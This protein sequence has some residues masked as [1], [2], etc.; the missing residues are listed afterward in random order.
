MYTLGLCGALATGQIDAML[1][2]RDRAIDGPPDPEEAKRYRI[3]QGERICG[4]SCDPSG[5]Y[6]EQDKHLCPPEC[7]TGERIGKLRG[8]R[9]DDVCRTPAPPLPTVEHTATC[10]DNSVAITASGTWML[11]GVQTAPFNRARR[12][13]V[14]ASW[15]RWEHDTP[16]VLVCFLIGRLGLSAENLASLDSEERQ[17]HDILW[18]PNATDAG[19]PTIK[20]YHWWRAAASLLPP[21]GSTRG[22]RIAA[23]VDDDSFLHLGNLVTD[24]QKLHCAKHLHYGSLAF[25]GYDP[26]I[27]KMC[28]WSWQARGGNYRKERCANRGAYEPFPFMN[29]VLELLSAPLVRHVARSREIFDFVMRA[30]RAVE[31]RKAGGWGMSLKHGQRGPR[32]WRQNEDVALGFW[33][34]RAER[35]GAFNVTWV[36]INDRAMNMGC[37]STK[38]MYQRPRNDTISVHFLKRPGGLECA[39]MQLPRACPRPAL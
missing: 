27:W 13:G 16:G 31:A 22:L 10:S 23:K 21:A 7:K 6:Y 20:G 30:E 3:V 5:P 12:D 26:S 33:L 35:K 37:I 14:R 38:G 2:A 29:G 17:H 9:I 32:V 15:K 36:R 1:R 28:G 4:W 19:V 34:S 18:L 8:E 24:M 25:T 11:I 39:C